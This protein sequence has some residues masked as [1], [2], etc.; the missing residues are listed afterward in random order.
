M[1]G[2]D[3]DLQHLEFAG[4]PTS[5]VLSGAGGAGLNEERPS[6]KGRGPFFDEI[7]GFTHLQVHADLMTVRHLDN[8][9]N[10]LHKFTKTPAG[11]VVILK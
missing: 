5:F 7:H 8:Q 11:E 9:G 1:G 3:H 6:V 2:H 10:L 4:H